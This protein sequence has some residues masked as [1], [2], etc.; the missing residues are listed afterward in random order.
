MIKNGVVQTVYS[1]DA[2]AEF[3][4]QGYKD[5]KETKPVEPPAAQKGQAKDDKPKEGNGEKV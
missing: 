4:K 3:M 1:D 5:Y 2:R